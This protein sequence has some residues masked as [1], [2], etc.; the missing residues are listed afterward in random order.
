MKNVK[1]VTINGNYYIEVIYKSRYNFEEYYSFPTRNVIAGEILEFEL[2]I[3]PVEGSNINVL[4]RMVFH[5]PNNYFLKRWHE[6]RALDGLG[7][8]LN[9]TYDINS[10][11]EILT[12]IRSSSRVVN[13]KLKVEVNADIED[14]SETFL[15]FGNIPGVNGV[16]VNINS[17]EEKYLLKLKSLSPK[18]EVLPHSGF[19][20]KMDG[21]NEEWVEYKTNDLGLLELGLKYGVYE[22][23]CNNCLWGWKEDNES[24]L[25]IMVDRSGN[26]DVIENKNFVI[27]SDYFNII[28]FQ[29]LIFTLKRFNG[30][31]DKI[32]G[33]DY[34]ILDKDDNIMFKTGKTGEDGYPK[35]ENNNTEYYAIESNID[36]L[37]IIENSKSKERYTVFISYDGKGDVKVNSL[38]DEI[39]IDRK[40]LSFSG[41]KVDKDNSIIKP[42]DIVVSDENGSLD[43]FTIILANNKEEKEVT[44]D[45]INNYLK[46][47]K[48][49]VN[50]EEIKS[51]TGFL[52]VNKK[53]NINL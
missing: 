46:T 5:I 53:K 35:D 39:V 11:S 48:R 42:K 7:E 16:K 17:I 19:K 30:N 37:Q 12:F 40:N 1:F 49:I 4:D 34:I 27:S 28:V 43:G 21:D 44:K 6:I 50:I 9:I 33:Y 15:S 25:K 26:I 2:N 20:I 38:K 24:L 52:R 14:Y 36:E 47:Y 29:K 13:L 32:A 18:G 10:G 8:I 3:S 41:Y 22:I 45:N 23:R 31:C 51:N